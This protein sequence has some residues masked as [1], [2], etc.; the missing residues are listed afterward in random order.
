M[1]RKHSGRPILLLYHP[2]AVASFPGVSNIHGLHGNTAA[3][4]S[5]LSKGSPDMYTKT[6]R[7]ALRK[8]AKYFSVEGMSYYFNR[9]ISY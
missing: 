2:C 3:I 1:G 6:E 4:H 8:S 9:K 7:H 5:Y